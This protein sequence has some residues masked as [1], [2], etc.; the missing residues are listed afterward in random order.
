MG[1]DTFLAAEVIFQEKGKIVFFTTILT[2]CKIY[3]VNNNK[4]A[5]I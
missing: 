3:N 1:E 2:M 4:T 5:D